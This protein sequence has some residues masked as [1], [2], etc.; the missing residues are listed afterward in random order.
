MLSKAQADR[1]AQNWLSAWNSHDLERILNHYDDDFE[2]SSPVISKLVGEKTGT[3]K[4]KSAIRDYLAKALSNAP[5][6]HFS[7]IQRARRLI[8]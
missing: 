8:A 4:G 6:L 1:F 2:M 7:L 3:L 5:E